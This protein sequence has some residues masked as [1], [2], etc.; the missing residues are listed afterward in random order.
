MAE[1]V[2]RIDVIDFLG[3][4]ISCNIS[5][6]LHWFSAQTAFSFVSDLQFQD[7]ISIFTLLVPCPSR[8]QFPF[9]SSLILC[10]SRFCFVFSRELNIMEAFFRFS[11]SFLKKEKGFSAEFMLTLL[12]FAG[13]SFLILFVKKLSQNF[14]EYFNWFVLFISWGPRFFLSQIP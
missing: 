14:D 6:P 9:L 3:F 4:H 11:F 1:L 5:I 8:L 7:R 12:W 10:F 13:L 2:P